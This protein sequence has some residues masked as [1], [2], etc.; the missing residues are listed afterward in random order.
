MGRSFHSDIYLDLNT[1]RPFFLGPLYNRSASLQ[2]LPT[3]GPV[4]SQLCTHSGILSVLSDLYAQWAC[5]LTALYTW[6][7]LTPHSLAHTEEPDSLYKEEPVPS[8]S[9]TRERLFP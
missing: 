8:W 1:I 6:L 9:C 2:P 4:S 7:G 3:D 5:L